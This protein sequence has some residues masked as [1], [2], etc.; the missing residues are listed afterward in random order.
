MLSVI[1]LSVVML[2]VVMLN[3]F[4]LN[5]FILNVVM[6][7]ILALW[8]LSDKKFM[9]VTLRLWDC[10]TLLSLLSNA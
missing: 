5:V 10:N 1:I 9:L 2:S 6:L 3:V 7:N 4:I 8:N